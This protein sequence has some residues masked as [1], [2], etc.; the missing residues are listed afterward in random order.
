[1]NCGKKTHVIKS[2]CP[3]G[4][5]AGER[6]PRSQEECNF[7]S[8]L[9]D[10]DDTGWLAYADWLDEKE[11][12]G[13]FDGEDGRGG[14]GYKVLDGR[15]LAEN[16]R[17]GVE[18]N[19]YCRGCRLDPHDLTNLGTVDY[20]IHRG[21]ETA[22]RAEMVRRGKIIPAGGKLVAKVVRPTSDDL[23]CRFAIFHYCGP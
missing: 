14:H 13:Y 17:N 4:I 19:A 16:I 11:D 5:W 23:D 15:T 18:Y 20:F 7:L 12:G 9:R 21:G 10:A 22:W 6:R 8:G 1:M 2:V 3:W